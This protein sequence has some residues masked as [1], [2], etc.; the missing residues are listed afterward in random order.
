M[1]LV[2]GRDRER[3]GEGSGEWSGETVPALPRSGEAT[4]SGES[5]DIPES[6]SERDRTTAVRDWGQS[7]TTLLQWGRGGELLRAIIRGALSLV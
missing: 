4:R 1:C 3:E 7:T 5:S 6:L 2:R